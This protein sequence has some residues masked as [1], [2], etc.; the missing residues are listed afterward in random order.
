[1]DDFVERAALFR[2]EAIVLTHFSQRYR[3]EQIRDALR[4]LPASLSER[5][6]PFLPDPV[7]PGQF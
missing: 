5:V 7:S 1:M 4:T 2:N 3:V 6:I